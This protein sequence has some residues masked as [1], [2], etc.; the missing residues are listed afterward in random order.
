MVR[1]D[2]SKEVPIIEEVNKSNADQSNSLILHNDEVNSF[3]FVIECLIDI[4]DHSLVQAEQCTYLVHY[5]GKCDV[6][7]GSYDYLNSMRLSLL[8][9]GLQAT[10]D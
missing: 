10:I 3:D 2:K 8:E 9:K 6:K 5:R 1:S 4:C 7:L